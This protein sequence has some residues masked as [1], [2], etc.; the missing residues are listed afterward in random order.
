M[1]IF[2]YLVFFFCCTSFAQNATEKLPVDLNT[3][4][5]T[6]DVESY[7]KLFENSFVKDTLFICKSGTTSTNKEDYSGKYLI[8]NSATIEFFSPM[9]TSFTGDTFGD[10]GIEFKTRKLNQL[11]L[12]KSENTKTEITSVTYDSI[13]LPWYESL[14]LKLPSPHFEISLL[15]YQKKYLLDLGFTE[16]QINSEMSYS[17]YNS[18]ISGGKKYP[19]KFNKITAVE[20]DLEK[21]EFDY[22]KK[23]LLTFGAKLKNKT[24]VINNVIIK[25]TIKK[26]EHFRVKKIEISLLENVKNKKIII[27]KKIKLRT[28]KNQAVFSFNY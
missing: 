22:L 1:N 23:T 5:V 27:S 12:F 19:R 26:R 17:E 7:T 25:C 16:T 11:Q 10:A 14:T 20:F 13:K 3:I 6:I 15:E 28:K 24:F 4:F 21:N 18:I 9:N 2:K 8:G